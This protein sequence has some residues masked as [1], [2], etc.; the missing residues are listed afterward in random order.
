MDEPKQRSFDLNQQENPFSCVIA[1][2]QGLSFP[3]QALTND[4]FNESR[5]A[6]LDIT[7]QGVEITVRNAKTETHAR[8]FLKASGFMYFHCSNFIY[9]KFINLDQIKNIVVEAQPHF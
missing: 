2:A 5:N 4:E 7:E 8:L 1:F 6:R 3:I 9:G